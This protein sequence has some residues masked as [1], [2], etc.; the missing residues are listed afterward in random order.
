MSPEGRAL[1][2]KVF[3]SRSLLEIF[4][5]FHFLSIWIPIGD[6]IPVGAKEYWVA[7]LFERQGIYTRCLDPDRAKGG[8]ARLTAW[9]IL[10]LTAFFVS[11]DL[12]DH[13]DWLK[14]LSSMKILKSNAQVL[15]VSLKALGA[16]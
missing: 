11:Y 8:A 14:L 4:A 6:W 5:W 1:R 16:D 12:F 7:A 2:A 15:C 3:A 9:G 13:S 10:R